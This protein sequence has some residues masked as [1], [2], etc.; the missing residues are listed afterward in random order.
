MD[1]SDRRQR[2]RERAKER[3]KRLEEEAALAEARRI[4]RNRQNKKANPNRG[5]G[6]GKPNRAWKE[7]EDAA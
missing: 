1:K 2:A 3:K 4:E 5:H 6:G 7:R